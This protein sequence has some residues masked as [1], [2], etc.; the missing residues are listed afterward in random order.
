MNDIWILAEQCHGKVLPVSFELLHRAR[1]LSAQ[2]GGKICA[3]IIGSDIAEAE[4]QSLTDCDAKLVVALEAPEL[5]YFLPEPYSAC[6]LEIIRKYQPEIIIASAT[7]TGKTLMP[8]VAMKSN[9][10]LTADCTRLDIEPATGLLLQTRPA[11]GGN[12]MATIKC[13]GFKPQMATVRPKSSP[14]VVPV[15]GSTGEIVR[16]KISGKMLFSRVVRCGFAPETEDINL[17]DAEKVVV[18]GRGIKK[19]ENLPL[20]REFAAALGAAIGASREVVD[21]GWLSYSHQVGL[22]GKTISPKLY[23]GIGVSGSIQ[24][25]AGMQTAETIVAINNDPEAQLFKV[26]NFGIVGNLF[27]VLPQLTARLKNGE[28]TW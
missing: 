10:G 25:L 5:E 1:E 21:R 14:R 2:N 26:A 12:I 23:V 13:A 15:P 20:V 3:M 8:Y 18:I 16:M 19:A 9:T 4:L 11:I 28:L 7:S 27:D 17:Q 24:H 6:M 22:S